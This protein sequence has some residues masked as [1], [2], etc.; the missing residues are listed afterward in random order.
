[1]AQ[2]RENVANAGRNAFGK[3]RAPEPE[4]QKEMVDPMVASLTKLGTKL[5]S[6]DQRLAA[7]GLA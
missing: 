4:K 7:L 3:N 2:M 6:I 5:D 1:M